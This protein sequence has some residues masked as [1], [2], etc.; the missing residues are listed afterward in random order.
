MTK[1]TARAGKGFE[2]AKKELREN[3]SKWFIDPAGKNSPINCPGR[4]SIVLTEA[5]PGR[6]VSDGSRTSGYPERRAD[7][8]SGN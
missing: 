8:P 7:N 5:T 3:F 1:I 2:D 6:V 4:G